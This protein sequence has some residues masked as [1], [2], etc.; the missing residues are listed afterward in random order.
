MILVADSG[1]TKTNW[2]TS[3]KQEFES[4]GF[5]PFF[6]TAQ[7]VYDELKKNEGL[8]SI[9]SQVQ[10]IF[11]YGA[12][13]SSD[14]RNE[15]IISGLSTIFPNAHIHVDHD[16]KAAAY[17]TYEG[18]KAVVCILGTGSNS[19]V[20]DGKEIDNSVPALGYVLGDEGSGSYFGKKILADFI[21]HKLPSATDKILKE[22][23]QLDKEKIFWAVY[24][25]PYANVYLAKFAK[26]LSES[27][28]R[29]YIE[30]LVYEGFIQFY[31]YHV[32]PYQKDTNYPVHFVGSI[33]HHFKSILQKVSDEFGY[34][35]GVVNKQPIYHLLDWH[36][37]TM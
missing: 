24:N 1:S 29:E 19:C 35:L 7:S 27:P 34:E 37:I 26:L 25:E 5:N 10:Q 20:F 13:C 32:V 31:K 3:D 6:H 30:Q 11:F 4:I 16:M 2:I 28:D 15:I 22:K 18:R 14:A 23:Y 17:A 33:A 12:G 8:L 9:A 21:Y 36:L